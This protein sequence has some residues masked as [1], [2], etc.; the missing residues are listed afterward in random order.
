MTTGLFSRAQQDVLIVDPDAL[1]D[2]I[3]GTPIGHESGSFPL[4]DMYSCSSHQDN[5]Q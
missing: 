2:R 3:A 4:L 1:A 5:Q